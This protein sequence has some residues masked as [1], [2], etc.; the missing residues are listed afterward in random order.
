[1]SGGLDRSSTTSGEVPEV[2]GPS[3]TLPTSSDLDEADSP[4]RSVRSLHP[5]RC[6][7]LTVETFAEVE[8]DRTRA[9]IVVHP[10]TNYQAPLDP[11]EALT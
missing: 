3:D 5:F 1:M 6:D 9:A 8:P 10:D 7:L 2:P 11:G 4:R